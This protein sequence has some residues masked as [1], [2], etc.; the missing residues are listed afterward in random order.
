MKGE[1]CEI[2]ENGTGFP[3]RCRDPHWSRPAGLS[4]A[5]AAVLLGLL[6]HRPRKTRRRCRAG[7]DLLVEE[8]VGDRPLLLPPPRASRV[9]NSK[10]LS[11]RKRPTT[12]PGY[13]RASDASCLPSITLIFRCRLIAYPGSSTLGQTARAQIVFHVPALCCHVRWSGD[14][15]MIRWTAASADSAKWQGGYRRDSADER[16][17]FSYQPY[18]PSQPGDEDRTCSPM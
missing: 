9:C 7:P 13:R 18:R 11:L 6:A 16:P 4:V 15:D 8:I 10:R 1:R 12:K 2:A 17:L 5:F 3:A 14:G